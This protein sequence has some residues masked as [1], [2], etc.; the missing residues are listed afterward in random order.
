[1]HLGPADASPQEAARRLGPGAC[2]G[3][4]ANDLGRARDLDGPAVSYLGVG[5]VFGTSS[6]ERPAAPLGIDGLR[7]IVASV[8]CP[9]IAIGNVT[10]DRVAEVLAVGA[11][12]VAVLSDVV[13]AGDPAARTAA[14]AEAIERSLREHAT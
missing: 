12:G 14:F 6:K 8:S 10:V 2:I 7:C 13:R 5:P 11:H 9:V 1:V 4:T 3:A